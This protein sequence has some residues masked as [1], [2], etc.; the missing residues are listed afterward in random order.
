M[1]AFDVLI[2]SLSASSFLLLPIPLQFQE[3]RIIINLGGRDGLL[4]R[5]WPA[6]LYVEC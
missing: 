3:V 4:G 2:I 6:F 5:L 1:F